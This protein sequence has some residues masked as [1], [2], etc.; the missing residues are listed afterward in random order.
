[1]QPMVQ[2]HSCTFWFD[3]QFTPASVEY[4]YWKNHF[5]SS[6]LNLSSIFIFH[7]TLKFVCKWKF[8]NLSKTNRKQTF[9]TFL[10]TGCAKDFFRYWNCIYCAKQKC[11]VFAIRRSIGD[12]ENFRKLNAFKQNEF[13]ITQNT[14]FWI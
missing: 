13:V 12:S 9:W 3:F 2:H 6:R 10:S 4:L 7:Q 8:V 14:A 11:K 5:N 1:M